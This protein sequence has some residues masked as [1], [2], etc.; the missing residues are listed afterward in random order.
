MITEVE[1]I[2]HLVSNQQDFKYELESENDTKS[3]GKL[4]V[5]RMNKFE[6]EMKN[7]LFQTIYIQWGA[8]VKE[9]KK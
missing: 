2:K 1:I 4:S 7:Q 5:S 3:Q 9:L 8:Y 6:K